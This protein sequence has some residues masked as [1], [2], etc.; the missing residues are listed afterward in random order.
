V[1]QAAHRDAVAAEADELE[2]D[3]AA[4]GEVGEAFQHQDGGAL[5]G[6]EDGCGVGVGD[7]RLQ[8]DLGMAETL[9]GESLQEPEDVGVLQVLAEQGCAE[10][11]GDVRE[12]EGQG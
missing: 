9:A 6:F 2:I 11:E 12:V 4:V 1:Q 7:H 5:R 8:A 3:R 10:V